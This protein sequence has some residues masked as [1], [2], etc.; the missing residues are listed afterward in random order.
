MMDKITLHGN[1]QDLIDIL[2]SHISYLRAS[3]Y[4]YDD[5]NSIMELT[6]DS[7]IIKIYKD[8]PNAPSG[9]DSCMKLE[10]TGYLKEHYKNLY[11]TNKKK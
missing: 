5:P 6:R 9:K 4:D 10:L 3:G 7:I 1:K 8:I 2:E 11:L